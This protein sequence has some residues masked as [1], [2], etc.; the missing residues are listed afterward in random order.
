MNA[1]ADRYGRLT[2]DSDRWVS[3]HE[4]TFESDPAPDW[5]GM[6][7]DD[8]R[9]GPKCG[10]PLILADSPDRRNV[11][12]PGCRHCDHP[13]HEAIH[14]RF[15][16]YD[17]PDFYRLRNELNMLAAMGY[18]LPPDMNRDRRYNPGLAYFDRVIGHNPRLHAAAVRKIERLCFDE[19]ETHREVLAAYETWRRRVLTRLSHS[20]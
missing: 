13:D 7:Y 15:E 2:D 17:R 4:H 10:G 5:D 11:G 12:C 16:R 8:E 9:R 14:T 18:A 6:E 20:G 3:G 1:F 19:C